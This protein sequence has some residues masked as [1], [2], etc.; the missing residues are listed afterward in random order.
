VT[1]KSFS[2]FNNHPNYKWFV[3][4]LNALTGAFVLAAPG[5]S[6][7]VLFNEISGD[8]H[9][10]L[11]QVG[12]IWSFGSLPAIITSLMSGALTDRFGPK[13]VILVGTLVLSITG[14]FRGLTTDFFSLLLTIMLIGILAPL[15]STSA[16]KIS[17]LWFSRQQLGMANGVFT[18]GLAFGFLFS[19][20]V[21]ASLLSPWLNGWRNVMFFYGFLS[22]LFLIPWYFTKASPG[23]IR[24]SPASGSLAAPSLTKGLEIEIPSIPIRRAIAHIV[25][26]KNSWLLGLTIM[27]M[28]GCMQSLIG[29]LPLYLRGQGWSGV[30]ADGALALLHGMSMILVLPISLG[31]DRLKS[32]K[33]LMFVM[34]ALAVLGTG[35]LSITSGPAILGAVGLAGMVRDGSMAVII[36]M[37]I[38][39][40]G[41]GAFYAGTA[42]GFMMLFL[43]I[44]VFFAAPIGNQLAGINPSLPFAF[45]AGLAGLGIV[46]LSF[47][48]SPK[49]THRE[50]MPLYSES[51]TCNLI[52]QRIR[53]PLIF[54]TRSLEIRKAHLF[55]N[56]CIF[57]L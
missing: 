41:V 53:L 57:S 54:Q 48:K 40:E 9:L 33:K 15:I 13:R 50:E 29:Y 36:T 22:L 24:S 19:S 14:A 52:R 8:L 35:M 6:I 43:N 28:A 38:E 56:Y 23:L 44:G 49:I 3:L 45:W 39:T 30:N 37:A 16:F 34:L 10:S 21:S 27:G 4:I 55:D 26:I 12:M 42:T 32:R 20:L 1:V 51:E 46:T 7:S 11:L 5:M 31:S 25:K 47:V 2:Q 17:G 18:M